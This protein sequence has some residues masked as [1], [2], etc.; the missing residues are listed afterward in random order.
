MLAIFLLVVLQLVLL[1]GGRERNRLA[2]GDHALE[3]LAHGGKGFYPVE[4][5]FLEQATATFFQRFA[6]SVDLRLREEDRHEL[7][8]ALSDLPADIREPELVAEFGKGVD[9]GLGMDVDRIDERAVDV[10]DDCLEGVLLCG[11]AGLSVWW[12]IRCSHWLSEL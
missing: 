3:Q 2:V 11:H 12:P 5:A 9:P 1:G 7:V 4:I 8:A 6:E 10:E